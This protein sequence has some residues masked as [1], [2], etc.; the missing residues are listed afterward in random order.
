MGLTV[1]CCLGAAGLSF[2]LFLSLS[3][4]GAGAGGMALH[5]CGSREFPVLSESL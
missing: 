1:S 2:L 3:V 5:L 4:A